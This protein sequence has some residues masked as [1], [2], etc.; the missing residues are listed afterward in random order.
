MNLLSWASNNKH[1]FKYFLRQLILQSFK[2]LIHDY[3]ISVILNRNFTFTNKI[4]NIYKKAD[5][6]LVL[7]TILC[8]H[9][10]A[11]GML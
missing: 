4:F 3:T 1:F 2:S 5:E 7:S 10:N 9:L 6:N 8:F 11:C